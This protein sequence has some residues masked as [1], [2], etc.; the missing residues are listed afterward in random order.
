M[1]VKEDI[2]IQVNKQAQIHQLRRYSD[3]ATVWLSKK[4]WFNSRRGKCYISSPQ[5][6]NRFWGPHNYL[7][8]AYRVADKSLAR[9]GRKQATAKEDFDVHLSYLLS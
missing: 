5:L 4:S 6:P 7:L 3:W 9:P 2:S 1:T 8:T